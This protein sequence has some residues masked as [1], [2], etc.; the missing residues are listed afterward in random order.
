MYCDVLFVSSLK[1][2]YTFQIN[3]IIIM[4]SLLLNQSISSDLVIW[5]IDKQFSWV[6]KRIS[7]T[8]QASFKTVFNSKIL[9]DPQSP[10]T[11]QLVTKTPALS[12][13]VNTPHLVQ[14]LT[15]DWL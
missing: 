10:C 7:E 4:S 2:S 5:Q 11:E 15:S 13:L 12:S 14:S 8:P 1:T 6:V 9:N 3:Q